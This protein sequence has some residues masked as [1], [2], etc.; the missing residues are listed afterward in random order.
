MTFDL[1]WPVDFHLKWYV[2]LLGVQNF[3]VQMKVNLL[4]DYPRDE[5][6]TGP[7]KVM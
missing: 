7:L 4:T 2:D 3:A 1:K 5:D 6:E